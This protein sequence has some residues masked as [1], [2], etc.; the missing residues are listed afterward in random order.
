VHCN[1]HGAGR[2]VDY[3]I[4][5]IARIGLARVEALEAANQVHKWTREELIALKAKYRA[6]L[7]EL[8]KNEA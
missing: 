6:C 4:G 7:R 2:A 5:L 3:R 8:E 1:R